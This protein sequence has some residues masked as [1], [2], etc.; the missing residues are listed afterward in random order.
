[1]KRTAGLINSLRR[2]GRSGNFISSEGH[3]PRE[4]CKEGTVDKELADIE[5][6]VNNGSL[7]ASVALSECRQRVQTNVARY[8]Y[9]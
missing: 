2:A 7:A 8:C 9:S 5:Y 1:M 4:L 3:K 6:T